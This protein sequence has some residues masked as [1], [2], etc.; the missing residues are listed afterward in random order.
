VSLILSRTERK[1]KV[2][3]LGAG[4]GLTSL[5]IKKYFGPDTKMVIT[6]KSEMLERI[7]ENLE[8]NSL[9]EDD[10]LVVQEL[11]W[12]E[13][14]SNINETYDVI[15]AA[16]VVY[17]EQLFGPLIETIV[18]LSGFN[19]ILLLAHTERRSKE[20]IFFKQLGEYFES[21]KLHRVSSPLS[22]P[23]PQAAAS[24]SNIVSLASKP[25]ISSSSYLTAQVLQRSIFQ[26]ESTI[27]SE[28]KK[29]NSL[30]QTNDIVIFNMKRK[31]YSNVSLYS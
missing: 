20:G 9:V 2:I 18:A 25:H 3:E 27:H 14:L 21:T 23:K 7:R 10:N 31:R 26:K 19:T 24:P 5:A 1:R 6:E 29:N 13:N 22:S 4:C 17:D 15:V 11:K 12:G 16:E 30:K 28:Q 8:L